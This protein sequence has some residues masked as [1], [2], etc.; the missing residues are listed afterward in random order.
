MHL[1]ACIAAL[2]L[3]IVLVL[4]TKTG[5]AQVS[6]IVF[7]GSVTAMLATSSLFHRRNW[8]PA[9]KRWIALLDHAMI[10]VLIAGTYTPFCLLVLHSAWRVPILATVWCG[11][12]VGTVARLVLPNAS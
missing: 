12:L 5:V 1:L 3:G 7:A 11:A 4:N 9:R 10:F 8:E 6:A 2:P